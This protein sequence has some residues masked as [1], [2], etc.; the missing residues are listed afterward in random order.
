LKPLPA[1]RRSVPDD[2]SLD[3]FFGD[4]TD[5]GS[6][7]DATDDGGTDPDPTPTAGAST[8]PVATAAWTPDGEACADC[9]TVVAFR[10]RDDESLVCEE[11][12]EW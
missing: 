5:D 10:W 3:D 9:G 8:E 11:C 1:Q 4:G 2:A 12:K 7:A 6:D